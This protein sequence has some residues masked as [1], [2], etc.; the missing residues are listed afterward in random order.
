MNPFTIDTPVPPEELI[1]REREVDRLLEA[2]EGGHNTRLSAPRRYGKTSVLL[3]VQAE[4]EKLGMATASVDFYGVLSLDD[5][6]SRIEFAYERSLKGALGKWFSGVRRTLRPVARMGSPEASVEFALLPE[7]DKARTL[8]TAL[9]LPRR[10]FE[11]EGIR[12]LVMFDEFQAVLGAGE[13]DAVLRS[14]IQHH[15]RVASYIFAGSH[16]G[17]MRELFGSKSKPL[18]GQSRP[19]MLD[20]LPDEALADYIARKFQ[21]TGRDPGAGLTPLL[22]VAR[23][24]PQRVML[25][26]HH[27]WEVTAKGETADENTFSEALDVALTELQEVFERTWDDFSVNERR[28]MAAVAWTGRWGQGSSLYSKSTLNRFRLAKGSA[29]DVRKALLARGEIERAGGQAVR[30]TDPLLE[31]WIAS[32]RRSRV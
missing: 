20:P 3:K 29:R 12:T 6:V 23:G 15:R 13:V 27:L 14:R 8:D 7:S 18:Y 31:L 28:V 16:P 19:L 1:D 21:E 24:H 2:A 32:E 22:E 17:M 9:D 4:A 11:R 26:A 10:I 25:L 30:I 5:V